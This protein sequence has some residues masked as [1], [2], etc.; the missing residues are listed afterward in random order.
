MHESIYMHV[1]V[2]MLLSSKPTDFLVNILKFQMLESHCLNRKNYCVIG[3]STAKEMAFAQNVMK[4]I[5]LVPTVHP[6]SRH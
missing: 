1:H 6:G 3:G 4:M 5:N 2:H